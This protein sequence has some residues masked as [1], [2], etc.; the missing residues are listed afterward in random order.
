MSALLDAI[1][2]SEKLELTEEQRNRLAFWY[3]AYMSDSRER[4]PD[5]VRRERNGD[6]TVTVRIPSDH[7]SPVFSRDGWGV[8]IKYPRDIILTHRIEAFGGSFERIKAVLETPYDRFRDAFFAAGWSAPSVITPFSKPMASGMQ[9]STSR[10]GTSKFGTKVRASNSSAIL[11]S[12]QA[13]HERPQQDWHQN[14]DPFGAKLHR[15]LPSNK[16]R[17]VGRPRLHGVGIVGGNTS[18]GEGR[19]DRNVHRCERIEIGRRG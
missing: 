19:E 2:E 17:T 10:L 1:A 12:W 18:A 15:V 14:C 5:G 7:N 11:I 9:Y 13:K 8:V 16:G 4:W 6:N 3:K